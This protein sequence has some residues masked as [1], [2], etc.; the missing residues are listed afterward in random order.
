MLLKSI[1]LL[2]SEIISHSKFNDVAKTAKISN[3]DFQAELEKNR[4]NKNWL[5][6]LKKKTQKKWSNFAGN[7]NW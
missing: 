4:C 3:E 1:K 6:N 2:I 5:K 7:E